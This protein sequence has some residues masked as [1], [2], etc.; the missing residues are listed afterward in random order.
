MQIIPMKVW[1]PDGTTYKTK[2]IVGQDEYVGNL[3]AEGKLS[4]EEYYPELV[5][6]L[7]AQQTALFRQWRIAKDEIANLEHGILQV[8]S[9]NS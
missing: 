4:P 5:R 8:L 3:V 7:L 6:I 2:T 1:K 9:R